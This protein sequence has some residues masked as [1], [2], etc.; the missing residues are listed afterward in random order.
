MHT[1]RREF[2]QK[3]SAVHNGLRLDFDDK[4]DARGA[5][6]ANCPCTTG[7]T[8]AD[9]RDMIDIAGESTTY[10]TSGQKWTHLA[11][12]GGPTQAGDLTSYQIG[13]F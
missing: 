1:H 9:R 13:Q 11:C 2:H 7:T 5:S 4:N 10:V 3:D 8:G 12:F 6:I